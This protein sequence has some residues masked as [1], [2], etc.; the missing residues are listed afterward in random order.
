MET[1]TKT[2]M[3][4]YRN[5]MLSAKERAEDLLRRM[6]LEEK[7]AQTV[8]VFMAD[9]LN[10]K[11]KKACKNGMG[12]VSTLAARTMKSKEQVA[13]MQ[14]KLQE[15]IMA[16]SPHHIPA[17]FHMEGLCGA[18]IQGAMS[19]PSGIGRASSFDPELEE[20]AGNVV[21]RQE[22]CLGITH[23]FAPV[24]DISRDPRL[25]RMGE[26]YGEDPV[27]AAA[28]GTGY[29]RG[30]QEGETGGLHT[31]AVA[32]HF[33]GFH[34]SEGGIHGATGN[35]PDR[36]IRETYAK[37]F[38]AAI[39]KA[40]LRGVMPCYC[41]INGEAVSVSES[42]LK[43][44]LRGQMGFDGLIVSD[45]SAVA[46]A[47]R[48][49][50][51]YESDTQA[52][53]MSMQA[54]M[55]MELPEKDCYNDELMEWFRNGHKEIRVLDDAVRRILEAKFR[56]GLFEHPFALAGRELDQNFF[57]EKDAWIS[58]K[59][60]EESLV[61]LKNNGVLPIGKKKRPCKIAVIGPHADNPRSF[62]GG[63]TH[64]SMAEA[65]LAV[66][67]SLAGI[68]EMANDED[69]A[70]SYIPGTQIQSDDTPDFEKLGEQIIPHCK[71][72]YRE[73]KERLT[74]TEVIYAPGYPVAGN[75]ASHFTE[76][77]EAMK[78]ADL[79]ILTLGG[80]HGSCSVASMGEGVDGTDIGLPKCQ[81]AFLQQAAKLNIPL[82]GIH[83]NGRPVSSDIADEKLDAILE[84]WNP[85]ENAAA[86]IVNVLTGKTNPSGKL[87]VCVARSAGQ[88][89]VYYCHQ[90]GSSWHQG[91]S[92][93][94]ANYVD[95]P[96]TPRY[97]F[98]HGL[99]YT[100]FAY[101]D[102]TFSDTKLYT[103]RKTKVSF[104]ISNTGSVE[105][106]ETVQLYFRDCYASMVRPCM[107]LAGFARV[108]LSPG[109]KKQVTFE[110]DATQ[111]AFI[112]RNQKW[113][114]EKGAV[115]IMV[116]AASDDIRLKGMAEIAQD[117]EIDPGK[118][119]FWAEVTQ[120][121]A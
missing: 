74:D 27:L 63:Y 95:M 28:M 103:D 75:D 44:L 91:E 12:S 81:E 90:N 30:L 99:S 21:A 84:A 32:K 114:S 64:M 86:A 9:T 38:Q 105:G 43:D 94:F 60:A 51:M 70:V 115:E 68:G 37:P 67:N 58:L 1:E 13:E 83:F 87:P 2:E 36:L 47:H 108:S 40:G 18:F 22:R 45:Y 5:P 35:S 6:S 120:E 17:I 88:V 77:L 61:L 54:G 102:L 101:E 52:G 106:T 65:V 41:T 19:F 98:G 117:Q 79:C 57:Q 111:M 39:S 23:T 53:Y 109:E 14:R 3:Q 69:R 82:V 100:T 76:A 42:L 121:H 92:I 85:S 48:I 107:E 96:H 93:G 49:Q 56:M 112:G 55:D 24:L 62:F 34:N 78:G 72:L 104:R 116:G 10:D 66:T 33:I 73:L 118:R 26:T 50:H 89:P 71:S 4:K 7:M 46:N 113:I 80:K 29:T 25:G 110:M 15:Y 11:V 119:S 8:G 20:K 59:S 31:E 97:F 16:Q